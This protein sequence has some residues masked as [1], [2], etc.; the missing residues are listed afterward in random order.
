MSTDACCVKHEHIS[1]PSVLP[2]QWW[3]QCPLQWS[4]C[5]WR[6]RRDWRRDGSC[7]A[8]RPSQACLF[9]CPPADL[10]HN[11]KGQNGQFWKSRH[12]WNLGGRGLHQLSGDSTPC[13]GP[14]CIEFLRAIPWMY[15]SIPSLFRIF[16]RNKVHLSLAQSCV[17]STSQHSA[18][19]QPA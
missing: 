5:P 12:Y 8:P 9:G 10:T 14:E 18:T 4:R 16:H 3:S 15:W 17:H 2:W 13:L 1:W 19:W 11:H 6:Q 7:S